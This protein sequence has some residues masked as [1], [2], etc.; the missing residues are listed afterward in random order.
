MTSVEHAGPGHWNAEFVRV[1]DGSSRPKTGPRRMA[2]E[3]AALRRQRLTGKH[4]A[5][6]TC[7]SA[8]TAT[9]VLK[10]RAVAAEPQRTHRLVQGRPSAPG[11]RSF[12]PKRMK[13]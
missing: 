4:V 9:R 3:I 12:V 2:D 8:A 5:S 6:Q 1:T 10:G 13:P 11:C 7:V